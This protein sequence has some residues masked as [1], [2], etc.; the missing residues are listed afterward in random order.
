MLT[1]GSW[2]LTL[3]CHAQYYHLFNNTDMSL[4]SQKRLNCAST[5]LRFFC[6][7]ICCH[8]GMLIKFHKIMTW[9]GAA[10]QRAC[11]WARLV[12]VSQAVS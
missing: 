6:C 1:E 3:A 10:T 12:S 4:D 11:D 7:Y 2:K 8:S 9:L 5:A